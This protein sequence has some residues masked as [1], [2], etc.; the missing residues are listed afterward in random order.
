MKWLLLV[1]ALWI[2]LAVDFVI[3]FDELAHM[4]IHAV[5]G[6]V[7]TYYIYKNRKSLK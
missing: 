3:S 2:L 6:V 7:G 4:A 1:I 5:I